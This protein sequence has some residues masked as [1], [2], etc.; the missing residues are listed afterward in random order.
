ME[1]WRKEMEEWTEEFIALRHRLHQEPELAF[2]EHGTTRLIRGLLEEYG[3]EVLDYPGLETGAAALI[4]GAHPGPTLALREDI[5]ALPI[6]ENTGLPFSSRREGVCHACGHDIHTAALLWAAKA[7]C[8]RRDRLHGTVKLIFQCAEEVGAGAEKM[9]ALGAMEPC[10]PEAVVGFHCDP[11]L[12]ADTVGLRYGPSNASFDILSWT[13]TGQGGHGAYPQLC[14]DP[15]MVSGYL[16]TQLQAV[17]S[18]YNRPTHPAVLTIGEIHGGTAPNI[19]PSQVTMR[20][21]LRAFD[22]E[23][24]RQ[25]LETI[26][27]ITEEGCRAFGARGELSH[28]VGTPAIHNHPDIARRVALAAEAV[29]GADRL[30][31]IGEPSLG[32]DDF[33]CWIEACG[34]R[35]TQFLVGSQDPAVP[36]SGLGLHVAENIFVDQALVTAAPVLVQLALD[37]LAGA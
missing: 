3:A 17:V 10:P 22:P 8:R 30:R 9:L 6:R 32:S 31:V 2:Q 27:R 1:D 21:T 16:L 5:D 13:V 20:G 19:I 11:K 25:L 4:R 29:W 37:Y 12:P 35:G 36:N 7:L 23:L 28:D 14:V 18:R 26:R 24:R 15:V 33:A 34:G